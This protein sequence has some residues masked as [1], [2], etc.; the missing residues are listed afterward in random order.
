[1]LQRSLSQ[2]KITLNLII[3]DVIFHLKKKYIMNLA[4]FISRS[5]CLVIVS[6]LASVELQAQAV[7]VFQRGYLITPQNEILQGY[8]SMSQSH[9]VFFKPFATSKQSMSY[10]A[11]EI[12]GVGYQGVEFKSIEKNNKKFFI[13]PVIKG[14]VGLYKKEFAEHTNHIFFLEKGKE[15]IPLGKKDFA[16]TIT[17]ALGKSQTLSHFD[18]KL[19]EVAF[20]YKQGDLMALVNLYNESNLGAM[21]YSDEME[22]IADTLE[23]DI[24]GFG[25]VNRIKQQKKYLHG[26]AEKD[27]KKLMLPNTVRNDLIVKP[28]RLYFEMFGAL[29]SKNTKKL[30]NAMTILKPLTSEIDA[31]HR[32]NLQKQLQ[33][34]LTTKNFKALEKDLV[35][36]VAGG[37]E[38]L[39]K[40]STLKANAGTKKQLIR[41]AFVE[42]LEIKALLKNID[43]TLSNKIVKD[44]RAAFLH[45]SKGSQYDNDVDKIQVSLNRL[46]AKL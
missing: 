32:G 19:L 23:D 14:K 11:A 7:T 29:R 13:R 30:S 21:R 42:F 20:D 1:M 37:V 33:L 9:K 3:A 15:Y 2:Q 46:K 28:E 36:L 34:H 10:T 43:P 44:F 45:T 31:T 26:F 22:S 39:L 12:K 41:Q 6:L 17:T 38:S 24:L 4:M 5:L 35:L 25:A 18:E 8:V 16:T 27:S 40:A